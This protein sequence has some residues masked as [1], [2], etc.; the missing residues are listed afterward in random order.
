[1]SI[2]K[3]VYPRK[4]G[5]FSALDMPEMG[6]VDSIVIEHLAAKFHVSKSGFYWH[7]KN[8]ND[9][10]TQILNYWADEY[11]KI[12]TENSTL[13]KIDPLLRL[14]VTTKMIWGKNLGKYDLAIHIWAKH[15]TLA[16]RA[17]N[18]VNKLRENFISSI[19]SGLGFK[20]DELE[21]RTKL[22]VCYQVLG[23]FAWNT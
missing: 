2:K 15:D 3:H 13:Q 11:T 14:D 9:L 7:F 19:F 18:K 16:R 5:F 10:L 6:G 12:V 23:G 4:I 8:R 17:V 21:M 20:G 1:M 22:Y